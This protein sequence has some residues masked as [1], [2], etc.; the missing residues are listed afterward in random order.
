MSTFHFFFKFS[1]FQISYFQISKCHNFK[2]SNFK[3]SNFQIFKFP[4]FKISSFQIP[5]FKFS[6]FTISTPSLQRTMAQ[7]PSYH[8]PPQNHCPKLWASYTLWEYQAPPRKF[9]EAPSLL[10]THSNAL[11]PLHPAHLNATI[12]HESPQCSPCYNLVLDSIRGTCGT[13][14]AMCTWIHDD[15]SKFADDA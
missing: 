13:C 7:P 9:E 2:L 1:T 10:P 6:N 3:F 12:A 15:R 8:G 11:S 4:N 14:P 5:N